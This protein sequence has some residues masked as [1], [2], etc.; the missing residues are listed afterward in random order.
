MKNVIITFSLIIFGQELLAQRFSDN[1]FFELGLINKTY[2]IRDYNLHPAIQSNYYTIKQRQFTSTGSIYLNA[3]VGYKQNNGNEIVFGIAQDGIENSYEA[4]VPSVNTFTPNLSLSTGQMKGFSGVACTNFSLLYKFIVLNSNSQSLKPGHFY[5]LYF[6]LGLTYFYKPNNGI[7]NLTGNYGQT[8]T[9]PDSNKVSVN[10]TTY[11]LP[12]KF[13]NSFKLNTG[14]TFIIG[15]NS[16][17]YFGLTL[18][19]ITNRISPDHSNFI[20][21]QVETSVV[22]INNKILSNSVAYFKS[23]GNGLYI[24]ISK[25]FFPFK[26]YNTRQQKKLD[27]YKD[28]Q[29]KN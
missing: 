17:E 15:K 2:I 28:E 16:I 20:F 7:E 23:A 12:V 25:R 27:K 5:K 10:F 3:L 8:F 4:I 13:I 22:N 24:Q 1:I 6:N 11:N 14:M 21:T 19:Y 18:S 26:W 9:A 29:I